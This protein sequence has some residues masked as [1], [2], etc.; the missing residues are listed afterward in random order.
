MD[1]GI[2]TTRT[3][4]TD[5]VT[6]RKTIE[7]GPDETA[8]VTLE[9]TTE[10]A[11]PVTVRLTETALSDIPNEDIGLHSK[12]GADDW[13]L[14]EEAV[15]EREIDPDETYKAIYR[16]ADLDD[17]RFEAIDE[18]P[19]VEVLGGDG[20]SEVVD[21]EDSE[22]V[23]ELIEGDRDSMSGDATGA[24]AES[25]DAATE[26]EAEEISADGV[27]RA[28]LSELR[29]GTLDEEVVEGLRSELEP[30][31]SDEVRIQHLQS[32]VSDL[33][34]FA[35]TLESF[36]DSHG[37]PEDAFDDI[38][39]RLNDIEETVVSVQ[40]GTEALE[41]AVETV[42]TLEDD[43]DDLQ[44]GHGDLE[45]RLETIESKLETVSERLDDLE[46]FESRLSGVF[47]GM[48]GTDDDS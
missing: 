45:D 41:D 15:L 26:T 23:R 36:I 7:T 46:A 5:G 2:E 21:Q 10:L 43:V 31:R 16:V 35:D 27:A 22:A 28:L 8:T 17:D 40:G 24:E 14:G 12:H 33:A 34:A 3:T 1:D 11:A 9:I 47:E 18:E 37:T 6:V 30:T 19:R 20:L 42:E 39:A 44:S 4:L 29:A 38:E 48:G 13:E 32:Q 25:V